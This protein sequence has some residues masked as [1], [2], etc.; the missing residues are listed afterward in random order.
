MPAAATWITGVVFAA[1]VVLVIVVSYAALYRLFRRQPG[2]E[3]DR[4]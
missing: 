4:H 3:G 2:P 1:V